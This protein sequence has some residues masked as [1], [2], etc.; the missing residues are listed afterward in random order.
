M[1]TV[2]AVLLILAL[3]SVAVGAELPS[4]PRPVEHDPGA[5][6]VTTGFASAITGTFTKPWVGLA[7]GVTIGL[8]ANLRL[9]VL[10]RQGAPDRTGN[11]T[12]RI[13]PGNVAVNTTKFQRENHLS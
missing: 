10:M 8:A 3:A 6:A 2:I 7:A 11:C 5:W 1:K 4:S 13:L 12:H 9:S